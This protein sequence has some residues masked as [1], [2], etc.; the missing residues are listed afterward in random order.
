MIRRPVHKNFSLRLDMIALLGVACLGLT[1][2]LTAPAR[3]DRQAAAL[4]LSQFFIAGRGFTHVVYA[5]GEPCANGRLHVYLE[6]DG[7]AWLPGNRIAFDPTPSHSCLLPL[8]A[9]DPEPSVYLG[10]PCYHGLAQEPGCRP[11][12]WTQARYGETVVASMTAALRR[13]LRGKP[14]RPVLIGYSGGGTLAW[15]IASRLPQT[16]KGVITLAGNLDVASWTRL[17]GY[18]PLTASLDPAQLPPLPSS[19]F[20]IHIAGERDDNIPATLIEQQT[21]RQLNALFLKLPGQSH[22]CPRKD[23]WPRILAAIEQVAKK[24]SPCTS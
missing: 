14:C 10:R 15:L 4:G 8:M 7:M 18:T 9:L 5:K 12:L 2:C 13:L 24:T 19:I 11:E 1:G 6:G 17:H 20:Q 3:L 21:H 22:T 23:L 16:V